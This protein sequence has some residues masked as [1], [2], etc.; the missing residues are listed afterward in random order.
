MK[1]QE[2]WLTWLQDVCDKNKWAHGKSPIIWRELVDRGGKGLL[3][4]GFNDFME[5]AQVRKRDSNK[6]LIREGAS[7]QVV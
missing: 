7:G 6:D 1:P 4:G 2:Q 3:I 5:Y